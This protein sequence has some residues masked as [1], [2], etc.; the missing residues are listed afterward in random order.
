MTRPNLNLPLDWPNQQ[1]I[2]NSAE[3]VTTRKRTSAVPIALEILNVLVRGRP[4]V[5]G[6]MGLSMRLI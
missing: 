5:Y 3:I 4:S 2:N 6:M 1:T